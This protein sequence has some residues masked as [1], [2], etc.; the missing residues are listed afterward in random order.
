MLPPRVV[1]LPVYRARVLFYGAGWFAIFT[2]AGLYSGRTARS[3]EVREVVANTLVD[4]DG[5]PAADRTVAMRTLV[6]SLEGARWPG[7]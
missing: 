4:L 3:G 6:Q 5:I 2:P 7:R 1:E